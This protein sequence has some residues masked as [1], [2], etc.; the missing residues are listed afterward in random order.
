MYEASLSQMVGAARFIA[1]WA[2]YQGKDVGSSIYAE[3]IRISDTEIRVK[4]KGKKSNFDF[5]S[6]LEIFYDKQT[7][8]YSAQPLN[9]NVV[10]RKHQKSE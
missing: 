10:K 7:H 5:D 8:D 6:R 3:M 2:A 9:S 1:I 4:I